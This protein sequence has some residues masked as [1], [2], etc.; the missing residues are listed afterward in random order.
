MFTNT[1]TS[2]YY[3]GYQTQGLWNYSFER[4][5][6]RIAIPSFRH[7]S[8]CFAEVAVFFKIV[9]RCHKIEAKINSKGKESEFFVTKIFIFF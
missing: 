2:G 3:P 6:T 7:G 8:M 5:N 9:L 4:V 1:W